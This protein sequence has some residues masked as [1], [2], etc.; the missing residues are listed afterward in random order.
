MGGEGAEERAGREGWCLPH[1]L[2]H[3][4]CVMVLLWHT[5]GWLGRCERREGSEEKEGG[6]RRLPAV[7]TATLLHQ[8]CTAPSPILYPSS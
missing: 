4:F 1:S 5:S 6:S 7:L 8:Y 3:D 2:G